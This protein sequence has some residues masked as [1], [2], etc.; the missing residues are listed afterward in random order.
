MNAVAYAQMSLAAFFQSFADARRQGARVARVGLIAH[1]A[2][3]PIILV[4]LY[5]PALLPIGG[6]WL[7]TFPAAMI[8]ILRLLSASRKS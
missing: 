4:I 7:V 1:G 8:G 3:A 5:V 2:M 6:L